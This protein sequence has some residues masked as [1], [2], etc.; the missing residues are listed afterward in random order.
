MQEGEVSGTALRVAVQRAAHQLFD[1]PLVFEDSLAVAILGTAGEAKLGLEAAE[2]RTPFALGLRSVVVGRTRYCD[3]RLADALARGVRQVVV[4]GAGLDTLAY[5]KVVPADGR[6]FEVDSPATQAWK[7]QLLDAAGIAAPASLT[8]IPLDF[9]GATLTDGLRRGKVDLAQ[10][11]FFS[12]LGVTYYL[13]AE[14]VLA[15]LREV[16]GLAPGSEIVFDYFEPAQNYRAEERPGFTQM[17]DEVAVTGEPWKCYF[18]PAD[19]AGHLRRRGFAAV[20]DL[21]SAALASRYFAGRADG[22]VPSGPMRI[23]RAV[24][25]RGSGI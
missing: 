9:D 11:I 25:G 22:L 5:R 20:D 24:V 4:L 12:W 17:R 8:F 7:R 18:E 6:I 10:P 13:S 16:S 3:D 14:T 2:F 15:M 23:V 19:M 21:G 1:V